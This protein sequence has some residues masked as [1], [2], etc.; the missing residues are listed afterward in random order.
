MGLGTIWW[1]LNVKISKVCDKIAIIFLGP[2]LRFVWQLT[3]AFMAVIFLSGGGMLL[4]GRLALY[5]MVSFVRENPP[6]MMRPWIENLERYYAAQGSWEGVDTLMVESSHGISG[7]PTSG[8]GTEY[9]IATPDGTIVAASDK[10][11]VGRPL[12]DKE[13]AIAMPI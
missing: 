9:V 8:L 10:T 1:R 7:E 5:E 13:S 2:H 3:L 6:T 4:A 12:R 11:R